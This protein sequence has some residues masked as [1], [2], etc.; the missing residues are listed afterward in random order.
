MQV[1]DKSKTSTGEFRLCELVPGSG[2]R[3]FGFRFRVFWSQTVVIPD[4]LTFRVFLYC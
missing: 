2:F 1:L 3:G 4:V